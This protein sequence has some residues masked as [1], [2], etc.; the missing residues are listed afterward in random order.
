MKT[1]PNLTFNQRVVGSI[2]TALTKDIN[3]LNGTLS[4]MKV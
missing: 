3:T 4:A 2:P 1:H